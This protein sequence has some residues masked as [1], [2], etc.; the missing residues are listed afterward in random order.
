M[1]SSGPVFRF[2]DFKGTVMRESPSAH[3]T[4][5]S[6]STSVPDRT[7]VESRAC[8]AAAGKLKASLER[9][10]ALRAFEDEPAHF[11]AWIESHRDDSR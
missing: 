4:P 7:A 9:L 3:S 2:N 11:Q 5:S 1:W 6:A 10:R 8:A